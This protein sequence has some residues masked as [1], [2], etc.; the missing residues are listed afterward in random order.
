MTTPNHDQA[1]FER[2]FVEPM[3]HF[4]LEDGGTIA[5][6]PG[7]ASILGNALADFAAPEFDLEL[8]DADGDRIAFRLNRTDPRDEHPVEVWLGGHDPQP[9]WA[10]EAALT[11]GQARQLA[12]WLVDLDDCVVARAEGPERRVVLDRGDAGPRP[13]LVSGT[14]LQGLADELNAVRAQRSGQPY[15]DEELARTPSAR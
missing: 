8:V 13:L 11:R 14:V 6:S 7:H 3:V 1:E 5:L 10:L 15:T 2:R 12:Q 4:P 9:A